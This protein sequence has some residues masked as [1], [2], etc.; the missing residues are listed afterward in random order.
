[1]ERCTEESG[2]CTNAYPLSPCQQFFERVVYVNFA[3][4][5]QPPNGVLDGPLVEGSPDQAFGACRKGD[6]C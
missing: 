3:D 2:D 1:M 5:A 4:V 6:G